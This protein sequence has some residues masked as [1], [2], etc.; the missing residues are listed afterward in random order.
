MQALRVVP[1]ILYFDTFKEF[2]EQFQLGKGDIL[3]TNQWM[4]DPYVKPLGIDVPVIYQEKYGKGEPSD[5]MIDAMA[6]DMKAYEFDRIIAFGGGASALH[7]S[8]RASFPRS[9]RLRRCLYRGLR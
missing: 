1:E 9:A 6:K 3:V 8:L 2:N 4:Y 7:V 5:E